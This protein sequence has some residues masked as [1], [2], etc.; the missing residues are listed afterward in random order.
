MTRYTK[1]SFATAQSAWDSWYRFRDRAC[2]YT[3]QTWEWYCSAFFSTEAE[4][5]YKTLGDG[6]GLMMVCAVSLG[7][8][9]RVAWDKWVQTE[10]AQ[11][12]A[13]LAVETLEDAKPHA[14]R[15]VYQAVNLIARPVLNHLEQGGKVLDSTMAE[16]QSQQ[17]LE[18]G[19][20]DLKVELLADHTDWDEPVI[21]TDIA[22]ASL[23]EH[24]QNKDL[25]ELLL[26]AQELGAEVSVQDKSGLVTSIWRA[27]R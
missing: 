19:G 8:A 27:L 5:R 10:E 16:A 9:A 22:M 12:L 4:Q 15:L 23:A 13:N 26:V 21:D 24:L 3:A 2:H 11:Q 7:M 25:P 20:N 17:A 6:L 1:L 18:D 14:E